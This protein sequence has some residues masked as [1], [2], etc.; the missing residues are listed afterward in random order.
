MARGK[1]IEKRLCFICEKDIT[2]GI[3]VLSYYGYRMDYKKPMSESDAL[4]TEC[5]KKDLAIA[6]YEVTHPKKYRK[7]FWKLYWEQ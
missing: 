3:K 6:H 7:L 4:C 1:K 5:A 2:K